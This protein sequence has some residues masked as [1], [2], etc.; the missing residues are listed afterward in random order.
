[1][2]GKG[3]RHDRVPL[4]SDVGEALADYISPIV[5]RQHARPS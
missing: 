1:M 2:Y 4:P 3:N 5:K